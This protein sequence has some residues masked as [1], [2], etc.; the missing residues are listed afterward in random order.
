MTEQGPVLFAAAFAAF[1]AAHHVGDYWVQHDDDAQHKGDAG[2]AGAKH[3]LVHVL[4]YVATQCGFLALLGLV[5]FAAPI[6]SGIAALVVSGVAH[7]AADRREHGLMFKLARLMPGKANFLR[8]AQGERTL[9]TGAWAL[10]QSW[11]IATSVFVP[12]LLIGWAA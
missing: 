2:W 8:F 1:Y 10:D 9:A 4:T 3:C 12:A 7:Y 11:H 5:G 6:W